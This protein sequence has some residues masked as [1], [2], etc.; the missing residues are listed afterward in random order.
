MRMNRVGV[1]VALLVALLPSAAWAQ[2]GEEFTTP[3]FTVNFGTTV[4]TT[5]V[6]LALLAILWKFAWGPILKA[7]DEREKGI[8]AALDEAKARQEEAAKLLEEHRRQLAEARKQA[9]EVIAEGKAAGE[10]VRKE[11]E[12]KARI[13]GNGIVERARAEIQR[14][15]DAALDMLRKE[16]VDL[17]L[18]AAARLLHEK[19]DQQKD[20]ELVEKFLADVSTEAGT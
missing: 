11:I 14:E 4:W 8:Q 20:R 6:F 16:S 2:G 13:E 7:A 12:E 3:L 17:A 1:Q 15:R 5:L 10:R 9:N 18:S 19:V